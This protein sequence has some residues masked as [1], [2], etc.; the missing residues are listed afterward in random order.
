MPTGI[1]TLKDALIIKA[2]LIASLLVEMVSN[3][4]MFTDKGRPVPLLCRSLLNPKI[5]K[6]Q[7]WK[8]SEDTWLV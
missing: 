2:N 3:V 6:S 5:R 8:E 1:F 7:G 4:Y